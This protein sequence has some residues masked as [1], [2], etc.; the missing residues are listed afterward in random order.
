V[1]RAPRLHAGTTKV[2]KTVEKGRFEKGTG[3][4]WV[5]SD[6]TVISHE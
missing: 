3:G 5:L 2:Y 6:S 4:A 1:R